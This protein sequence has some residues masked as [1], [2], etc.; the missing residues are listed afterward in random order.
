[1][2]KEFVCTECGDDCQP[3]EEC[4]DYAGT[5]C[6]YG[7]SGTHYTGH[8]VSDCCGA[9]VVLKEDWNEDEDS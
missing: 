2:E 7:R 4:F 9:D 1:M 8:F 5:H 6:T 3:V